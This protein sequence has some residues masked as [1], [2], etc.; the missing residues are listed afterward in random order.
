MNK[1]LS[2]VIPTYNMEMYLHRCLDSLLIDKRELLE[3]LVINDGS[4]DSSFAIAQEFES[5]YP[6]T[7]RAIDKENGNYGSCVNRGIDEAI[8]KYFRILDADDFFDTKSLSSLINLIEQMKEEPDLI[9]TD[10]QEDYAEGYSLKYSNLLYDSLR[11]YNIGDV[12]FEKQQYTGVMHRMTYKLN[13]LREVGLRHTE[14]ISYTDSEYCFYPL[15]AVKTVMFADIILYHY[16]IGR[17]G[18]TVSTASYQKN[19]HNL[20]RVIDRML[21]SFVEEENAACYYHNLT[22]ELKIPLYIYYRTLLTSKFENSEDLKALDDRIKKHDL[23]LYNS[24]KKFKKAKFIPFVSLWRM[25]FKTNSNIFV[26]VYKLLDILRA[27]IK[28]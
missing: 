17:E 4:K 13:V 20:Y 2:I 28:K 7:F 21:N 22:T 3:V 23:I 12:D 9:I 6:E 5:K 27:V 19:I 1:L 18:Q 16:Q 15:R 14:G 10:Y 11:V 26:L 25:G 8:G 24:L